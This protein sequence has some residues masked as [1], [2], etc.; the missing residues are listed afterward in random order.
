V[1]EE[2]TENFGEYCSSPGYDFYG[3]GFCISEYSDEEL[4]SY[5]EVPF[6]PPKTAEEIKKTA[7]QI[8]RDFSERVAI[9]LK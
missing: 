9:C 5:L 3:E 7:E 4:R 2:L 6:P 8:K 1:L